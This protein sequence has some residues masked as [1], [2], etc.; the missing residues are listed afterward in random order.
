[1]QNQSG[2]G[3]D[4]MAQ[5]DSAMAETFQE[6]ERQGSGV[7][8]ADVI[9]DAPPAPRQPRRA[10][11]E[12]SPRPPRRAPREESPREGDE[13]WLDQG[14]ESRRAPR[15]REPRE[16][17]PDPARVILD[18]ADDQ[19]DADEQERAPRPRR[20]EPDDDGAP[21]RGADGRFLPSRT[22]TDADADDDLDED[23]DESA[24]GRRYAESEEVDVVEEDD[25]AEPEGR[26][27]AGDD[28]DEDDEPQRGQAGRRRTPRATQREIDRQVEARIAKVIEE[29]DTLRQAQAQTQQ[30]ESVAIDT[31][32]KAIGTQEE[33]NRLQQ[34]VNNPRAPLEQRNHAAA[35][36]NRYVQNEQYVRT[37]RT[38]LLAADR[39]EKAD[40]RQQAITHLAKYQ[41]EVD[42]Q[43]VHAGDDANTMAHVAR[44]A[45][46]AE[47][48]R[49]QAEIDRL[50][51]QLA[52]RGGSAD[53][54]V[55]RNGRFGR[56]SLASANGRRANGRVATVDPLRRA[57][58]YER[59]LGAD[60]QVPM[61]TDE[62]LRRLRDGEI[63][64]RDL[65]LAE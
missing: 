13:T 46:L 22:V 45:I 49:G 9:R 3:K 28:E 16:T 57:M 63:T 36:L 8:P 42:P 26:R 25:D 55:V 15:R 61:P 2:T 30:A 48:K 60:S 35:T 17:R 56:D 27:R 40:R 58:G 38:A 59:G 34:I 6:L 29:R 44:Q 39:Q 33:R 1:V 24:D 50:N 4:P 54:R 41:I 12:E 64:L 51:R 65:G 19:D 37:Y 32:I 23:D 43:I 7:S 18:E 47:R 21:K 14:E 62:T 11:K 10:P 20:R 52:T 53:E 31:L 5:L